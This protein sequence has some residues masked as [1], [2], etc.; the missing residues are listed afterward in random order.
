MVDK[1]VSDAKQVRLLLL[2]EFKTQGKASDAATNICDVIASSSVSYD[3]ATD[4]FQ[5]LKTGTLTLTSC[6]SG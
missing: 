3:T 2:Y 5:K 4:W 6:R 1:I